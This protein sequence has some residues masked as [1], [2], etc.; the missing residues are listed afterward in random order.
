M[1]IYV[2]RPDLELRYGPAE[3]ANAAWRDELDADMVIAAA[4]AGAAELIDAHLGS[5]YQLPLS[6][7]PEMVKEIAL[8]IAWFKLWRVS[9]PDD[10]AARH[11]EAMRLLASI[12]NG[13]LTLQLAGVSPSE[14]TDDGPT[15]MCESS[16]R[17]FGPGSMRGY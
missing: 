1:T 16:G 6:P 2:A 15:V 13:T 4:C 17:M 14:S 10:V 11:R 7:L 9:I 3:V 12:A 5:R 8:D